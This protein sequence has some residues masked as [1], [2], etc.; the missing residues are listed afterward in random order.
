[1]SEL[2]PIPQQYQTKIKQVIN[3]GENI[4]VV[5]LPAMG[6]TGLASILSKENRKHEKK[7]TDKT[8]R[9]AKKTI[10]LA[11]DLNQDW[12]LIESQV[13]YSLRNFSR[14]K[15]LYRLMYYLLGKG[16]LISFVLDNINLENIDK[17]KKL[18]GFRTL[19]PGLIRYVLLIRH[20]ELVTLQSTSS[21]IGMLFHNTIYIP[22]LDQQ[23]AI[24][25]SVS[26]CKMLRIKLSKDDI[27]KLIEFGGGIPGLLKNT[28]RAIKNNGN[29]QSALASEQL[30]KYIENLWNRF[31]TKEQYVLKNLLITKN[32]ANLPEANYLKVHNLISENNLI[33]GNWLE[34]LLSKHAKLQIKIREKQILIEG[35]HLEDIFSEKENNVILALCRQK[36]LTLTREE[37]AKII[38]SDG[39]KYSDWAIDQ[40]FSRMRKKLKQAGIGT[41]FILT[42]KKSG[43]KLSNIS[44]N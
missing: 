34:R 38:W 18:L 3:Q 37:V 24:S 29:L 25:W 2:S 17:L 28:L 7:T 13:E 8:D 35:I 19:N 10:F 44:I 36:S 11:I 39:T 27:K 30:Q 22:Y 31:S 14:E 42:L 32:L 20:R 41:E 33:N 12:E 23:Q 5:T 1:L 15:G 9:S 21:E 26:I 40:F 4:T 6:L 16:Y 43:Y